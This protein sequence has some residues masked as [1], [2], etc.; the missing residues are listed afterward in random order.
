MENNLVNQIQQL[1]EIRRR[2]AEIEAEEEVLVRA[3]RGQMAEHGLKV[4]RSADFEAQL[5]TQERL[6]VDPAKLQR[7]VKDNKTFLSVV[8][9][10][11][12]AARAEIGD[13]TLRRIGQTTCSVQLRISARQQG[14]GH[15][16]G[17]EQPQEW[18]AR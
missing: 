10:N 11:I 5:V 2:K 8:N 7:V 18:Q 6:A 12:T 3:V 1:G 15:S 16:T 17:Q 14:Q 9:V 4:V 13:K